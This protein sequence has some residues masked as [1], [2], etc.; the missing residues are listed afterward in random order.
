MH[1][2]IPVAQPRHVS[3]Q[4][5]QRGLQERWNTEFTVYKQMVGV[6]LFTTSEGGVLIVSSEGDWSLPMSPINGRDAAPMRVPFTVA[7]RVLEIDPKL[8]EGARPSLIGEIRDDDSLFVIVSARIP[9]R[10]R[11]PNSRLVKGDD[12]LA[13]LDRVSPLVRSA[14]EYARTHHHLSWAAR[15]ARAH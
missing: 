13:A 9:N 14:A 6:A 12:C 1:Q 8:I 15:A 3:I 7:K 5:A 11:I 2:S 10:L 4:A